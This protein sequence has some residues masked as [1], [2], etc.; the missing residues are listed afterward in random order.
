MPATL[1]E[2]KLW[3][4]CFPVNFAKFLLTCFPQNQLPNQNQNQ[5]LSGRLLLHL[6]L[7]ITATTVNISD[8][9][10]SF[11]FKS[12][13]LFESGISFSLSH[14]HRFYFLF[15]CFSVFLS[16]VPFFLVAANKNNYFKLRID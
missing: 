14:F 16:F 6:L 1:L 7:I 10:L 12:F 9:C 13:K 5:L 3:H 8:V 11:K 2:K 4:R 15:P